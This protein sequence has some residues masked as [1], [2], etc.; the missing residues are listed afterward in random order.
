M[1]QINVFR[2]LRLQSGMSMN[3]LAKKLGISAAAICRYEKISNP[4]K[5]RTE[6]LKKYKD[7]FGINYEDIFKNL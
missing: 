2:N 1:K 7:F 6:I 5:P 4:R 3:Q